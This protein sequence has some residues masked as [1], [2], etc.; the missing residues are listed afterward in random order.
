MA[1]LVWAMSV[2]MMGFDV[3][4]FVTQLSSPVVA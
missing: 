2:G 1:Y 3:T 4:K